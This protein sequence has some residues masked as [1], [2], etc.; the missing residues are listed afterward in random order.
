MPEQVSRQ[1]HEEVEINEPAFREESEIERITEDEVL[2]APVSAYTEG[3][4]RVIPIIEERVVVTK[5]L[6]LVEEI[7]TIKIETTSRFASYEGA[8]NG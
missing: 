6:V 3:N 8:K 2:D 5:R 1:V 7:V 4:T